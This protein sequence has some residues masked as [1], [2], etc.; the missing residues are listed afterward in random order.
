MTEPSSIGETGP[1]ETLVAADLAEHAAFTAELMARAIDEAVRQRSVARVALSGGNTPAEAY[2]RLAAL[3]LPWARVEWFW[4]DERAV[5]PD[6]PRSNF[7]NASRDLGAAMQ[8]GR[9]HRMEAEDP[10]LAAAARRYE[11][12][13]RQRFGVASAVDFDAMTLGVGEDGHTASLF[14]GLGLTQ[15]VDRLVVDV[16]PQ[17]AKGLEARLTLTAPVVQAARL[18]LV[19]SAGAAKREVLSRARSAGPEEEVPARVVHRTRGRLI[20][21]LDAAAAG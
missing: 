7:H 6:S 3:D 12:L 10:D 9:V 13:L 8:A 19:L 15:I 11:A 17:P 4:V 21:L 20:W 5:P 14:P 16:P 1:G 18:L 2:R